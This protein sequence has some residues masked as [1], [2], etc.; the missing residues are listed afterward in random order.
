MKRGPCLTKLQLTDRGWEACVY[1]GRTPVAHIDCTSETIG[2]I[3]AIALPIAMTCSTLSQFTARLDR[4]IIEL[5]SH[6]DGRRRC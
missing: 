2:L 6:P 5:Q 3:E 4:V 1:V